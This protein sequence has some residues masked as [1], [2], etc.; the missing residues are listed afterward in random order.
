MSKF[1]LI[2]FLKRIRSLLPTFAL[3]IF[4]GVGILVFILPYYEDALLN[5]KKE[6]SH[7]LVNSAISLLENYQSRVEIGELTLEE[8]QS[9]A[10]GRI[11]ALRYGVGNNDYLWINDLDYI[12]LV[13]P[14]RPDLED[15]NVK[16]LKDINGV[17][18]IQ[19]FV[20]LAKTQGS[21]Y[22][23]YYWQRVDDPTLIS[24]KISYVRLYQPW[25][26]VIGTGL[27]LDDVFAEIHSIRQKTI[28]IFSALLTGLSAWAAFMYI[29]KERS[30]ARLLNAENQLESS[31]AQLNSLFNSSFSFIGLLDSKGHLLNA[32]QTALNFIGK[33]MADVRGKVLWDTEWWTGD[34]QTQAQIKAG[35]QQCSTGQLVRFESYNYDQFQGKIIVDCSIKPVFGRD[36]RVNHMVVEGRDI[37]DRYNAEQKNKRQLTQLDILHQIDN[38]INLRKSVEEIAVLCFT[39]LKK[40]YSLDTLAL[41]RYES[42][43]QKLFNMVVH[44]S[45]KTQPTPMICL[46]ES[47][48][49]VVALER[50]VMTAQDA[51]RLSADHLEFIEQEEFLDFAGFPLI[52]HGE[53]QGVMEVFNRRAD[54]LDEEMRNYLYVVAGQLAIAFD[55]ATLVSNLQRSNLELRNAYDR[56]LEGWAKALELR[57]KETE[58][59][60]ERV[61]ELTI[62]L[63]RSM[64][65]EEDKI[66]HVRRGAILHDIGKMGIPDEILLKKGQLTEDEWIVMRDHPIYAFNLLSPIPYLQPA[67]DIP[68]C[69]HE[70]WNGRG[71]P[72]GIKEEQIPLAA[73]IFAVIDVWDALTHDR[74]YRSAWPEARV[75]NYIASLN[76]LQFDPYVV[77]CFFDVLD[78]PYPPP[79]YSEE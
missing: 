59:H 55:N 43:D 45:L 60:S 27:Y 62:K 7:E 56:T 47:F 30:D 31:E 14:H 61:T 74:P 9:R 46:G 71:Y 38:A 42:G 5:T 49:G 41:W 2:K 19:E 76:G 23:P 73:R 3:L 24:P 64:G 70:W 79:P 34:P 52:S 21:G 12:M 26:W 20:D 68:Y 77:E 22:V 18:L 4:I 6:L 69:H 51:K 67:L 53:I 54:S 29:S 17:F 78:T 48:V 15:T 63:A 33:Q 35:I 11:R 44:G 36:G 10:K 39:Q 40:I 8:A 58:D 72:R 75:L 13:H 16:N 1:G 37:Q 28:G 50:R 25:G 66:V 57:D 32:N 65:I